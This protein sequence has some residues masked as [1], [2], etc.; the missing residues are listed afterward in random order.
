MAKLATM[1]KATTALILFYSSVS[2]HDLGP[3]QEKFISP[4]DKKPDRK[5]RRRSRARNESIAE[6]LGEIFRHPWEIQAAYIFAHKRLFFAGL[7]HLVSSFGEKI[8]KTVRQLLNNFLGDLLGS[9][10]LRRAKLT[11]LTDSL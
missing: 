11:L 1:E 2:W 3:F 7:R 10:H 5:L 8:R 4:I 6:G 9:G